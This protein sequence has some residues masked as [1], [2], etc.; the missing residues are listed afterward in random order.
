WRSKGM[1]NI[2]LLQGLVVETASIGTLGLIVGI[3]TGIAMVLGFQGFIL[4]TIIEGATLIPV[5]IIIPLEMWFL[6][7][8]MISGII[9]MAILVGMWVT[10]TPISKQIRY[11][12]YT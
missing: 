12:D 5:D 10:M 7:F 4:N 9:I 3:I 2:Q 8:V 11:E 1:S 6:L